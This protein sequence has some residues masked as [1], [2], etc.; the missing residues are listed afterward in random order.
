M[1]SHQQTYPPTM[2][3]KSST[4]KLRPF[5][6][7]PLS[8]SDEKPIELESIDLSLYKDGP[9]NLPARKELA[10]KIE[11]SLSTYGFIS[12]INHGFDAEKLE[13][14]KAVAQALLEV[15]VEE[16]KKHL[17][18]ALKSDLED[19][20]KS[21]GAERAS[22]YKPKGYWSMRN[23]VEDSI[24][25]YN[26]NN[27]NHSRFFDTKANN[28]PEVAE[29]HLIEIAEYYRF[30]HTDTLRKLSNLTDLVLE[31]PEGFIY[32][33]Y[34]SVKDGDFDGSGGGAGRFML[35]DQCHQKTKRRWTIHG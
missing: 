6:E 3:A 13:H 33:N 22:G 11:K 30:L 20:S 34:Y 10:A 21:I 23:G 12:V 24:T 28:Y 4:Y 14:L 2:P 31:L 19:R 8:S 7:A 27:M 5:I 32:E 1:A 25:H 29:D 15:P 26:F 9:E 35:Y 18:G 16:Q 17:A